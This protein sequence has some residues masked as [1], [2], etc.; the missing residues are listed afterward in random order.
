MEDIEKFLPV[1]T[2]STATSPNIEHT[3][4]VLLET[5]SFGFKHSSNFVELTWKDSWTGYG[6]R[7]LN[8]PGWTNTSKF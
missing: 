3:V 7:K 4:I 5:F 6:N 1:C 2:N 8:F